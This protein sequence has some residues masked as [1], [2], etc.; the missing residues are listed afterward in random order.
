MR[1]HLIKHVPLETDAYIQMLLAPLAFF[2][3]S[4]KLIDQLIVH[5]GRIITPKSSTCL[6]ASR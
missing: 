1:A 3:G 4:V 2:S 5:R 6:H